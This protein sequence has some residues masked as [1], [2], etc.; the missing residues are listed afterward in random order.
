VP[1][2]KAAASPAGGS[3]FTH[4]I[5]NKNRLYLLRGR[6]FSRNGLTQENL[7]ANDG[8]HPSG[9]QYKLWVKRYY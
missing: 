3:T 9:E 7:V 4:L 2:R 1:L 8:L 6:D 5:A